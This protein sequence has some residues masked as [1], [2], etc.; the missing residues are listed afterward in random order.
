MWYNDWGPVSCFLPVANQPYNLTSNLNRVEYEDFPKDA[1]TTG[2]R[3]I[4]ISLGPFLFFYLLY[5]RKED[6]L[7]MLYRYFTV[8]FLLGISLAGNLS[9]T[10]PIWAETYVQSVASTTITVALRVGQAELQK[11]LPAPWQINPITGGPLKEANLSLVFMDTFLHQDAQGKPY[12][13]GDQPASG[14]RSSRKEY[15]NW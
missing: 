13:G 2:S 15:S 5:K 14:V 1:H 6:E 3:E 7:I 4:L 9:L 11:W 12:M 10:Q 8:L